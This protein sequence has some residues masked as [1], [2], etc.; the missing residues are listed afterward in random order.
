MRTLIAIAALVASVSAGAGELDGKAIICKIERD[1]GWEVRSP[2]SGNEYSG[3]K[4]IDG[5]ARAE[6]LTAKG[7]EM[8]IRSQRKEDLD[9][10]RVVPGKVYWGT[11]GNGQTLHELD[12]QTLTLTSNWRFEPEPKIKRCEAFTSHAS[13]DAA[14]SE[15]RG[16]ETE[17]LKAFMSRNKI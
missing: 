16:A 3:Y 4:F 13:Y 17:Y 9:R 12:R 10:Y 1:R 6:W 14:F 15:I 5:Y 2:A 8:E 11:N 7:D